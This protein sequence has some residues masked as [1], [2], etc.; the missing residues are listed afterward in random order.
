MPKKDQGE[1]VKHNAEEKKKR[2]RDCFFAYLVTSNVKTWAKHTKKQIL[3]EGKNLIL[4]YY[5]YEKSEIPNVQLNQG[6]QIKDLKDNN[7]FLKENS[8]EQN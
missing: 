5:F 4:K 1:R 6:L 7:T 2:E 8:W 3:H